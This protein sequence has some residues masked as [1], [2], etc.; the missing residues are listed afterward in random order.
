[1]ADFKKNF[2]GNEEKII[3]KKKLYEEKRKKLIENGIDIPGYRDIILKQFKKETLRYTKEFYK[4]S[5]KKDPI[6]VL[7]FVK[8]N[9]LPQF[10]KNVIIDD[11]IKEVYTILNNDQKESF[12]VF[13]TYLT[14]IFIIIHSKAFEKKENDFVDTIITEMFIRTFSKIQKELME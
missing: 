13:L 8:K 5:K 9:I 4:I 11:Y 10:E 7:K 3:E 12:N 6:R 2:I 1:M 14:G